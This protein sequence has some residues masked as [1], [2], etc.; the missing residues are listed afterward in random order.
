MYNSTE[1]PPVIRGC[2]DPTAL[3]YNSLANVDDSSCTYE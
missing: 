1:K 2:M 3:N